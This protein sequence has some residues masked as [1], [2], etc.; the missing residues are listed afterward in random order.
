MIF[1]EYLSLQKRCNRC[2]AVWNIVSKQHIWGIFFPLLVSVN[3]HFLS[4]CLPS[5]Q[6]C[7]KSCV[8]CFSRRKK[9]VSL[10][11][12]IGGSFSVSQIQNIKEPSNMTSNMSMTWNITSDI[13]QGQL[14]RVLAPHLYRQGKSFDV[15]L[16]GVMIM[17]QEPWDSALAKIPSNVTRILG[18]TWLTRSYYQ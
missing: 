9:A 17:G 16:G 2:S 3:V 7:C 5:R 18:R 14:F 1:R 4:P 11:P 6:L 13:S 10:A 15:A 8:V 12:P